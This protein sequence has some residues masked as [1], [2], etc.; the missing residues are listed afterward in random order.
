LESLKVSISIDY[1]PTTVD[2]VKI[3]DIDNK[4]IVLKDFDSLCLNCKSEIKGNVFLPTIRIKI[5]DGNFNQEYIY[6]KLIN[7]YCKDE[8]IQMI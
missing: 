5:S 3:I 7:F 4:N 8:L 6:K 1:T 2:E